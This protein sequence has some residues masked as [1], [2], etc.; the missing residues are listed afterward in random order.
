MMPNKETLY[1]AFQNKKRHIGNDNVHI[2]FS[3]S[4]NDYNQET[5]SV[6]NFISRCLSPFLL[7]SHH[8]L[9]INKQ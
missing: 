5:V 6:K 2:I 1:P 9:P 8:T 7:F 4:Q 3:D